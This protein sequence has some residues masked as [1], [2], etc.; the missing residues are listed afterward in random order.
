MVA[1]P[2]LQ[3]ADFCPRAGHA[4]GEVLKMTSGVSNEKGI[5]AVFEEP[6][7]GHVGKGGLGFSE[8]RFIELE[9]CLSGLS[10]KPEGL[11]EF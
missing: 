2:G 9:E 3:S 5:V 1:G 11:G 10:L 7:Q 4:G 8:G 6:F